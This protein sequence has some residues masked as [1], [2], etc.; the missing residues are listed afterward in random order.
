VFRGLVEGDG[1]DRPP[2]Q[3][4]P[5]DEEWTSLNAVLPLQP[6][7][8]AGILCG[9]REQAGWWGEGRTTQW[10]DAIE[11][12][13]TLAAAV[14]ADL[15]VEAGTDPAFHPGRC[16]QIVV[17]G[18]V[19]GHAGELHPRA[20]EACGLPARSAA[21][22]LDLDAVIAAAVGVRPA[23]SIGT[24]PVAKEDLA[25]VVD[26]GVASDAVAQALASGAGDL[27]ESIRLF[28][29]YEGT[30]VPDGK[31]SL[32]FALR[33]RAPDRTLDAAETAAAREAA[34][35]AAQVQVGAVLRA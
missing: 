13:R 35:A 16:A 8:V 1:P 12:V 17:G 7:H 31:K 14:G 22:E 15:T 9:A 2:L 3:R 20:V 6:Q 28:D 29:V 34:L 30:Q 23:P 5:T 18:H 10:S 27:L 25:V 21:F 32:A 26:R 11:I 4:R 19:V 24:Q 33:F